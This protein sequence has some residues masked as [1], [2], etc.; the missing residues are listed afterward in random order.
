MENNIDKKINCRLKKMKQA[1]EVDVW[2]DSNPPKN[3]KKKIEI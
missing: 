2:L 1:G 3:E